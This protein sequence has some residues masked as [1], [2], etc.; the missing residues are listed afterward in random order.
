MPR[1]SG[2]GSHGG[3]YHSSSHSSSHSS[4][5]SGG[6]SH[7]SGY[8]SSSSYSSHSSSGGSWNSGY[9]SSSYRSG[10]QRPSR[11]RHEPPVRRV[12]S[13]AFHGAVRYVYYRDHKPQYVYSNYETVKRPIRKG[14]LTGWLIFIALL[15]YGFYLTLFPPEK[16]NTNYEHSIVIQDQLDIIED[17]A[18]LRQ[19]M[20]DF[21]DETG[22]TPAVM[23]ITN[24]SWQPYYSSL[25]NKAYDL[26]VNAFTDESHWLIVYSQPETADPSFMDWHWEGM[27]GDDT[28]T[29][30]TED[31]ADDFGL[32]LQK[33]LTA[34][35]R[36][37]VGEALTLAFN[38]SLPGLMDWQGTP[39]DFRD[40]IIIV[41][42]FLLIA[43]LHSGVIRFGNKLPK[44]MPKDAV[45]VTK[46][47]QEV[48]CEY[49][50]GVYLS[51]LV[52]CP[53]CGA[54]RTVTTEE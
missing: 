51:S 17:K 46:Q 48:S 45:Q 21:L 18:S 35:T 28:V 1:S 5:S 43:L 42:V 32:R 53:H 12:S 29:I 4:W 24:E 16:L 38:E 9:H 40:A 22:I 37:T 50:S 49:C 47:D 20:Q 31:V 34:S 8:H 44:G 27:Q 14:A 19:A 25:A 26:Y 30:I 23:T 7:S 6:G 41:A 10:R 36:Y 39:E 52:K 11:P 13:K 15:V 54:A 2:G 33:Y 3:G